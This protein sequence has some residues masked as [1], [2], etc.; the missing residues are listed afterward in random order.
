MGCSTGMFEWCGNLM[1]I[2]S[3]FKVTSSRRIFLVLL[4]FL[5]TG[6]VAMDEFVSGDSLVAASAL[7]VA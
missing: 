6:R 2:S 1:K 5:L 4:I 3:D 7:T